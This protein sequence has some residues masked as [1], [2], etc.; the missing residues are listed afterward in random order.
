MNMQSACF[1]MLD[2]PS[3][4]GLRHMNT[5][6]TYVIG[7][8]LQFLAQS[9]HTKYSQDVNLT[10]PLSMFLV[11]DVMYTFPEKPKPN[12][13]PILLM[14][15]SVVLPQHKRLQGLDTLRMKICYLLRC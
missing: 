5:P 7:P 12:S 6:H 3:L 1:T 8:S 14:A 13:M 10:S 4:S 15:S 9:H 2:Y 11:L